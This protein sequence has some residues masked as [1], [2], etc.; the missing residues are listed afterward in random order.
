MHLKEDFSIFLGSEYD[1][2]ECDRDGLSL[3]DCKQFYQ[4][5]DGMKNPNFRR[6]DD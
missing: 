3:R 5:R 6:M 2:I 1:Q 4:H